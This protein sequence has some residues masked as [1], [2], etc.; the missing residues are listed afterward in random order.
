MDI[1]YIILAFAAVIIL[2]SLRIVEQ[3]TVAVVEFL[4]K[5]HR[6]HTPRQARA[7]IPA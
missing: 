5:Y 6:T 7:I 4:G 2:S 3:N 1:F